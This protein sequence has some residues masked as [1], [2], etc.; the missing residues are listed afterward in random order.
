MIN[1]ELEI[2]D[3]PMDP[4]IEQ[5]VNE[6]DENLIKYSK[7]IFLPKDVEPKT[8]SFEE[9]DQYDFTSSFNEV[10][11]KP[12]MVHLYFDVDELAD[13]EQIE[14]AYN[15]FEDLGKT[16][17][18]FS[19]GGY[20]NNI[21][22]S[23]EWGLKYHDGDK[24]FVSFHVVYYTTMIRSE[25]LMEIVKKC[26]LPE[27]L[28]KS[29]YKLA[30]QQIFRH[31]LSKKYFKRDNK[32]NRDT[33]GF[34]ITEPKSPFC[35]I[36]QVRGNEKLI[37][38]DVWK[39]IFSIK[40]ENERLPPEEIPT[41]KQQKETIQGEFMDPSVD[42]EDSNPSLVSKPLFEVLVHGFK[43]LII[44]NEATQS[45]NNEISILS[46]VTGLN[47]CENEEITREMINEALDW[48]YDNAN[49][50]VN[51]KN[52]WFEKIHRIANKKANHYGVLLKIMNCHNHE[53]F[54]K[55]I[56][57]LLPRKSD[58]EDFLTSLYSWSDYLNDFCDFKTLDDYIYPL[59]K[60][61]AFV[62]NGEFILKEY[63]NGAI[64]FQIKNIKTLTEAFNFDITLPTTEEEKDLMR[65]KH[66]KVTE[67]K[68]SSL[69]KVLRNVQVRSLFKS[70]IKYDIVG[71]DKKVFSLFRPPN[72]S[73]SY[74]HIEEKKDLVEKWIRLVKDQMYDEHSVKAFGHLLL[75]N[76]FLLQQRKKSPVFFIKYAS[77]GNTGKN[78]IDNSFEKL[79]N[80]F[81][82]IGV[83]EQQ[84]NEKH[85]GGLSQK[86]YRSYDEFSTENYQNKATNNIVK[87]LTNSKQ[88]VRSMCKDVKKEND[89]AIDVLNTNHPDLYGML[90]SNDK[91]LLSRFCIMR[92]KERNI[93]LS[94]FATDINVIDDESFAYS[95]YKYLMN[96]DLTA[97]I[98]QRL[99]DRYDSS[100]VR[101]QLKKIKGS[102]LDEFIESIDTYWYDRLYKGEHI[103]YITVTD[104]KAY[105]KNYSRDNK[106]KFGQEAFN[107]ELEGMG[108]TQ[109]PILV[110]GK[111]TRVYY[112]KYIERVEGTCSDDEGI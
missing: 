65:A 18:K 43:D 29:V 104:M 27:F 34:I 91:A 19:I 108:V 109:K 17:G 94:E 51:A 92:F 30:T 23:D 81:S 95:L 2:L 78:Y 90:N 46:V 85:N 72:P 49:L 64:E 102:P 106:F 44:H 77:S 36:V 68:T 1:E 76:A 40:D 57:P 74:T 24:H 5:L 39:N 79:Y 96:L 53:Y 63:N 12:D 112:R 8:I 33:T 56:I 93:N 98:A 55:K 97:F 3:S 87:R 26:N 88:T 48:I 66:K 99:F 111:T 15:Y 31:S 4:I 86:L 10:L 69:L 58:K 110:D 101:E 7:T 11:R 83:T 9:I 35:Q 100:I 37:T 82:L 73:L 13:D 84:L 103:E 50:T 25:D 41:E 75:V 28:D 38:K 6:K 89:Y 14:E 71:D 22:I 80:D 70:F 45:I 20:T 61:L 107:N 21:D 67:F 47:S 59:I 42:I 105:Y 62:N 52:K 32:D 60:C 16:F 54:I